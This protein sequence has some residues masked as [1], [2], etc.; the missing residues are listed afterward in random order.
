MENSKLKRSLTLSILFSCFALSL[1]ISCSNQKATLPYF[2]TEEIDGNVQIGYGL[3][4][5]DVDGDGK[6]DILLADKKQF[7]W[8]RNPDW[9][10]FIMIDSL[11]QK[12]NVCIAARDIN[13]DGLVEVAVGAQWNPGETSDPDKSGSVHYLVRPDDP[14]QLWE[15]IPLYHEPT[16]H[17]MRWIKANNQSFQLAVLPLHGI[18][19]EGGEGKGV[20]LLVFSITDGTESD[21]SH[22]LFD[23]GMHLTHNMDVVDAGGKEELWIGGKEGT[24][25]LRSADVDWVLSSTLVVDDHGFGELRKGK[26]MLAGIQPLHGNELVIYND[27]LER[28]VLT[29]SLKQGHALA[30]E[31]LL[32]VGQEQIVVG[33]RDKNE[34]EELGIKIFI[35]EDSQWNTWKSHWIDKNG[36]ACEDLKV[37]DLD[38]DGK[39]DII[40]AGRSTNNLRIYWNRM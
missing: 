9:Q 21:W 6:S 5:G 24:K 1:F 33:W 28:T 4:I 14:T 27:Q 19:N 40:A 15:A 11:T 10:R 31:D 23:L 34:G 36:M 16:I 18:D 38:G 17:R 26:K 25:I 30:C 13:G 20:N 3:A 29:D 2:E 35:S 12:D 7:V 32:G 37:A 8:Y 39:K 22:S